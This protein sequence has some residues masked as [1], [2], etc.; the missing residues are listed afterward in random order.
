[1][2]G[3]DGN[4]TGFPSQFDLPSSQYDDE[5]NFHCHWNHCDL[6]FASIFEFDHHLLYNHIP[7][8]PVA[9]PQFDLGFQCQWDEC[10]TK[11]HTEEDLVKHVKQDHHPEITKEHHQCLWVN[12]NGMLLMKWKLI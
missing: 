3:T 1:L 5:Y 7:E 11:A 12:D 10:Q 8:A 2:I 9:V 4:A 6:S